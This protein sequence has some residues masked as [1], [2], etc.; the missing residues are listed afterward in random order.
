MTSQQLHVIRPWHAGSWKSQNRL[1]LRL[2][3]NG[4]F[5]ES[6]LYYAYGNSIRVWNCA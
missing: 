2:L 4:A 6:L 1:C 3:N 5:I